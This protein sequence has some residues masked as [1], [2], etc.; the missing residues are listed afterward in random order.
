MTANLPPAVGAQEQHSIDP[1]PTGAVAPHPERP[2]PTPHAERQRIVL[3]YTSA[4]PVMVVDAIREMRTAGAEVVI[5][6]P[7][8]KGYEHAA[9]VASTNIFL[10]HR[11]A[12]VYFDRE[13]PPRRY[14]T[15]WASIVARN[16][17]RRATYKPAQ[18]LLGAATL[19]WMATAQN[20]EALSAID[21]A[22]VLTALDGGSVYSVWQA[23]RRNK[24]AAAING[25][26]PTMEH[27]GLAR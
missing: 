27:L 2:A 19:W 8:V 16:L 26:G 20:R 5:I 22:H 13:N 25:I 4:P 18:R 14:T 11:V 10:R 9:K 7:Q 21:Q 17:S 12:P 6:G 24:G 15:E 23:A 3:M 1:T